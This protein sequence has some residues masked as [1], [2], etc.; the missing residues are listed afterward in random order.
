MQHIFPL[1]YKNV[2]QSIYYSRVVYYSQCQGN[3][4]VKILKVRDTQDD[5]EG[6]EDDDEE[7]EDEGRVSPILVTVCRELP[8]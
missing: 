5:E 3:V 1:Q 4:K 2:L 8:K 7:G 6:G